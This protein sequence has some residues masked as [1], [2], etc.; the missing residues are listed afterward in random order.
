MIASIHADARRT[1]MPYLPE[2]H[3]DRETEDWVRDIV[4]PQ[5]DV[6]L[7]MM[8]DE[9]A[10]YI[11]IDGTCIDALYVRPGCQGHGVGSVLLQ[12]AQDRSAGE[13]ELWTF[14]RNVAARQF[15][16]DRGFIAVESTDGVGNEEREPD[17]RY[18]WTRP[19]AVC[20][21]SS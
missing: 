17:V 9:I 1:A 19:A 18:E 12:H 20:P 6:W 3:S 11:A 14:Q 4:L 21:A 13:L 10:G 8:H 2:L 7:A 5:Q 16:E 15:Y